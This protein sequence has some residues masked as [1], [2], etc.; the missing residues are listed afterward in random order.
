MY[1]LVQLLNR[2]AKEYYE[3]DSPVVSDAEYDALYDELVYW[4]NLTGIVLPDSPTHRV[5]GKPSS[6]FKPHTHKIRLY[7]LDKAKTIE[8]T[9]AFLQRVKKEIGIIP[10]MTV[11]NK[12]DGLTL[13]ITYENGKIKVA[14]TR[15]DGETGED[16]TAQ[17]KTIRTVPLEIDYKGLIE[18]QGE[19]I[20]RISVFKEYNET[21]VEPLKNPRNAAAGAV[22]NLDAKVTASRKL[23]FIAYN[24]GY[25]EKH[26][27]T[28]SEIR[29]FLIGQGFYTDET[30]L[31]TDDLSKISEKLAEI[32]SGRSD[33][34]FLIDGAV[35]KVNKLSY[36]DELGFTSKFPKWALAYKFAPE[37]TTTILEDV[38]WQIS[39]T[40]KL[41]PLA[42]LR[43]VD[44]MGVTVKRATLNNISDIQRKDIKI[45]SRVF[46]RRSNDV[47]P[48]ITGVAEHYENSLEIV[49]PSVCPDCGS[50][51]R[52][53][54]VFLYC[55]N[56]KCAPQ[57][58]SSL[59]HFASKG[60]MNIEGLSEKTAE[61]LFN[62][63]NVHTPDNLYD[64]TE[65][66]L[67]TLDGFKEKKANN[68]IKNI[69]S[70]KETTL[71][72]FIFALG[73]PNVGKKAAQLLAQRYSLDELR[74]A[75]REEI[76]QLEEFGDIT[77]DNIVSFFE[78]EK[79][80][81]LVDSLL[82][83]RITFKAAE[84]KEGPFT[85]KVVVL[86]GS[87]EAYKRSQ[88]AEIIRELGGTVADSVSKSVNLVIAGE[89][90]GS[91]LAKAQKLGIEIQGED[92][93]KQIARQNGF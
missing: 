10:E 75:K 33:L 71:D 64:L 93:F 83:K 36:R 63:L 77:A 16:V 72:R 67:M 84:V 80:S 8:E 85:G 68:L 7:S 11:E 79:N 87:L 86:T 23:D 53:E 58:I 4:E 18:I 24:I 57:I 6:H 13:S 9:E 19:V 56:M 76:S 38:K 65:E 37:E 74:K 46:I 30:F 15:G 1:E 28:Q 17:V 51:V 5:G 59:D 55:D 34:D 60:A 2:Y 14:A 52:R 40:G 22:R 44:L 43:P 29:Q 12:F 73:I 27:E 47:I 49:P 88:A 42:I 25:S 26:F 31:L 50:P 61:Q 21:A 90:A 91:K 32:E 81:A 41:N 62:D 92:W 48:E 35:L 54:G 69:A 70:S 82:S 78:D 20:M 45:N 89:E 66:M 39:R 3:E